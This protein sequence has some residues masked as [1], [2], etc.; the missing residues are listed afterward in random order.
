MINKNF[1]PGVPLTN[2]EL[3]DYVWDCVDSRA[4]NIEERGY[5][6]EDQTK[7]ANFLLPTYCYKFESGD[8]TVDPQAV[9]KIFEIY[10]PKLARDYNCTDFNNC[11]I[12]IF[13]ADNLN[14]NDD[15]LKKFIRVVLGIPY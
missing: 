5:K 8:W 10:R 2:N 9:T 3:G 4:I 15:K 13:P 11:T 1:Y 6:T 12:P 14:T 7:L